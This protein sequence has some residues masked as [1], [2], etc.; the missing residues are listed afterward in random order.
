MTVK[1]ALSVPASPSVTPAS[2]TDTSGSASSSVI[3][4]TPFPSAT[5]AF[6]GL[7]RSTAYVSSIS[8]RTSPLTET[9]TVFVS[10]PGLKVRVPLPATKSAGATALSSRV[11]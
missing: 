2:P 6:E 4:P 3:C 1:V 7:E 5:F 8:S 9:D 11:A 10:W